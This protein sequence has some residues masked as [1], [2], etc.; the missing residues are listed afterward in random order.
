MGWGDFKPLLIET[1][2]EALK[3]IQDKYQEIM[4]NKDYLDGV[5]KDGKEKAQTVA[6]NTLKRVRNALGYLDMKIQC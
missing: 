6:N 3:P 4:D 2:I 1:T 5:L